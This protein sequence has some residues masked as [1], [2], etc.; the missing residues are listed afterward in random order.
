MF[1]KISIIGLGYVGLPLAIEFGKYYNVI[2]FDIKKERISDLLAGKDI[3]NEIS[4][5]Q[6]KDTKNILYTS[7]E[8]DM[9][10]S[11]VF[12]VTV[13]TPID[14][15]HKPNL[16]SI[17]SASEIISRC[18]KKSSIIIYESTV[19]PGCT[20][21]VCVPILEK[22]K[23]KYN[24]DFFCGYSPERIV[25]GDKINTLTKI[26]K[27]VSGS[28]PD[29]A[30]KVNNLYEQIIEAGTYIAPSIKVAEAAK[31]IEN[32]QRDMNIAIINEF[33]MIFD[34]LSIDTNSVLKAA[35]TKW[36]FLSFKPGLVGGHCIG[37]DPYYLISKSKESGYNPELLINGRRINDN[38]PK[39]LANKIKEYLA[40]RV[41][42]DLNIVIMG[43]TFKPNTPDIRNTKVIDLIR[44][45]KGWGASV[46]VFDPI[47]NKAD[48]LAEYKII[49]S[50]KIKKKSVDVVILAVN[51]DDF[52]AMDLS[53][54]NDLFR[55]NKKLL[56]DIN[57]VYE[58]KD[59]KSFGIDI[60]RL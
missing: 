9:K 28:T 54:I 22:S 20:E 55:N 42:N 2:A 52:M 21:E 51:H 57:S 37:V 36:N 23:L 39:Y 7:S 45:I 3:T 12:I 26:K 31:V 19:Y 41:L 24:K 34:S 53:E 49:L 27:I 30:L 1:K 58:I 38:M 44:E 18:M 8:S 43:I 4:N 10:D 13:P 60:L 50:D 56:V 33:S 14:K 11:D 5:K 48:T 47:A 29:T 15:N 35:S 46:D 16:N 40:D 17:K 59:A 25:P 32:T 6:I